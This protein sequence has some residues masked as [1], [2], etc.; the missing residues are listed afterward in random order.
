MSGLPAQRELFA[1]AQEDDHQEPAVVAAPSDAR[2]CVSR[3]CVCGGAHTCGACEGAP[4][5]AMFER[6]DDGRPRH[7]TVGG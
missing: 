5:G 3:C 7:F 2:L 4:T 6:G 1:L